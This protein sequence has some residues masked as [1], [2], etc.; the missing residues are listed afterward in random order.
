MRNPTIS[1]AS[2]P[3]ILGLVEK[4]RGLGL[5]RIEYRGQGLSML[6][7]AVSKYFP[8]KFRSRT[9]CGKLDDEKSS[10]RLT[11]KAYADLTRA[12]TRSDLK[13]LTRT[14]SELTRLKMSPKI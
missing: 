11:P 12:Y 10:K 13:W 1:A 3:S 4:L 7:Q 5:V 6:Q 8:R 2:M 9:A 14:L